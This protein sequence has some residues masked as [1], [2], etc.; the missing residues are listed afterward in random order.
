[1]AKVRKRASAQTE[2]MEVGGTTAP[3]VPLINGANTNFSHPFV[4]TYPAN[5]YPTDQPRPVI[6]VTNLSGHFT[7][8][9]PVNSTITAD[10]DSDQLWDANTGTEQ[11]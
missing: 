3:A 5:G 7:G 4:M 11:N 6:N 1:M 8:V 9:F 10:V 2:L